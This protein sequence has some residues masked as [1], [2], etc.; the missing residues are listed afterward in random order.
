[1]TT[2]YK[3]AASLYNKIG[4]KYH[5]NRDKASNDVTELPAILKLLGN[6]KDK[7]ILDMGCGL[8]KHAKEFMKRGGI[9]TGYDASEKMVKLTQDHCRNKGNFFRSTHETASF[10]PNSFDI[11]N[12]SFSIN[13]SKNLE[14]IFNNVHSWLKPGGIFIF[15][16][17]HLVWLLKRTERMDC[18]RSH[19][20]WVKL[21]SYDLEI[22]N[23]Y[24]PMDTF[25]QLINTHNF[26]L[27]NLVETTIP[28]KYKGWSEDKYRLPNANVFKLQKL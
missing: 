2:K 6:L 8:G 11:C 19:K 23:Y 22:F 7:R 28:K 24:H 25:I 10:M 14:I 20:I 12:A 5:D 4:Q 1:M 9:V 27:L 3:T 21:H 26:K 17:P 15:S 13:Y 16:I 18:S